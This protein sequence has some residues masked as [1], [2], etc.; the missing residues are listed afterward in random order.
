[1]FKVKDCSLLPRAQLQYYSQITMLFYYAVPFLL[2]SLVVLQGG[3]NRHLGANFGLGSAVMLNAS[4]LFAASALF[5]GILRWNPEIFPELL[6]PRPPQSPI[7]TW[8]YLIPGLC[9]FSLVLG[10]PWSINTIG[11]GK[12][13]VLL[14]SAQILTGFIWDLAIN[15]QSPGLLKIL[16]GVLT[17]L[18]SLFVIFG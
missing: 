8:W 17:I 5:Y 14:I 9:G 6:R 4:V 2:G 16:G 7:S 15:S 1:M 11:S 10:L 13:F 3:L 18:G 12:T